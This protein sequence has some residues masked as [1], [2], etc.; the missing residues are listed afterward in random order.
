MLILMI[1]AYV[2]YFSA[3]S[4]IAENS[5][6]GSGKFA[7]L[8]ILIF[9]ILK[10]YGDISDAAGTAENINLGFTLKYLLFA[11]PET[12]RLIATFHAMKERLTS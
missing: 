1:L 6:D 2:L 4:F 12:L 9:A 8:V 3:A 11:M 5:T 10:M 7:V